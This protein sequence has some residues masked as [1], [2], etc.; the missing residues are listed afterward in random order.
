MAFVEKASHALVDMLDIRSGFV[1]LGL[2]ASIIPAFLSS[3]RCET[4]LAAELTFVAFLPA[5][6]L[7]ETFL[8]PLMTVTLLEALAVALPI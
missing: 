6:A 2:L 1:M 3:G 5:V 8:E 4:F 7:A